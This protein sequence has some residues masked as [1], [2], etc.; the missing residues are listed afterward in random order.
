MKIEPEGEAHAS[1]N[2]S[3]LSVPLSLIQAALGGEDCIVGESLLQACS[4]PIPPK[5][6]HKRM[7][8]SF[9]KTSVARRGVEN[10]T[11]KKT[12]GV[13]TTPGV[14]VESSLD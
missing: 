11:V 12:P 13:E 5:S 7:V 9:T 1:V 10:L 2:S 6:A 3:E 14:A 8:R 4:M